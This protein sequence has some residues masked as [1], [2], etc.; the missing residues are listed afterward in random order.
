MKL[1]AFAASNSRNSINQ[2]L[3][4]HAAN[5][6]RTDFDSSVEIDLLDINE[7]EMAL[8]STDREAEDGIPAA[9]HGFRA[10]IA[11]AD[12]VMISYAEHN[13]HYAAAFKNLFD[14]TSRIDAK[15]YQD[16]P[17]VVMATSPGPGGAASVLNAAITSA[18]FFGADIR[19]HLSVPSFYDNFDNATGTLSD[20]VQL[21]AL[22][23]A[24]AALA[25]TASLTKAA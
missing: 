20:P 22:H 8:Y 1:L 17:M 18:P 23:N 4:R 16:K 13:G 6:Y 15:V 24:L 25:E 11:A 19:G 5:L 9:A 12:A 2:T 3:V 7:F 21:Q 10:R 14:W